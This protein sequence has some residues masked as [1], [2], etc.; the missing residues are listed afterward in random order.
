VLRLAELWSSH[1]GTME[2]REWDALRARLHERVAADQLPDLLV[3]LEHPH[4]QGRLFGCAILRDAD[5]CHAQRV[6]EAVVDALAELG[7]R[8]HPHVQ[9]AAIWVRDRRIGSL[10]GHGRFAIGLDDPPSSGTT[11]VRQEAGRPVSL[12]DVRRALTHSFSRAHARE[13]LD[14]APEWLGELVR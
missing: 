4:L 11:S 8:P 7:V 1:L 9:L 13:S 6:E 10:A 14:V 2:P 12:R 3:T 5:A